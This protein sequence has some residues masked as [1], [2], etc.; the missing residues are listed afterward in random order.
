GTAP[1]PASM[2]G[3]NRS[4]PGTSTKATVAPEGRS[5]QAKPRSMVSPRRRSSAH[6]SG[7]MPVSAWI[8]VDLPWSTWP[9]VATTYTSRLRGGND[10]GPYRVV[11]LGRHAPQVEDELITLDPAHDR[12]VPGAQRRRQR[13]VEAQAPRGQLHP[14]RA[15]AAPPAG[16][17][18]D[19][20]RYAV[21]SKRLRHG[22]DP[23]SHGGGIAPQRLPGRWLRAAQRRLERGQGELVHPHGAGERMTAQPVD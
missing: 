21:R 14:G 18:H 7:C 15:A 22:L 12:R 17:P 16:R 13:G 20:G 23:R 5:V 8:S 2:L 3:T 9:A 1:I 4:C 6:R 19:L 11:V 10:G